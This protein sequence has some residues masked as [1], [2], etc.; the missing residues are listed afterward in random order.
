MSEFSVEA[1]RPRYGKWHLKDRR[2]NQHWSD[3]GGTIDRGRVALC[4]YV[5][6]WNRARLDRDVL[7]LLTPRD[8]PRVCKLCLRA[9]KGQ[10]GG[11]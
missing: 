2:I 10:T 3:G 9:L 1:F 5:Q 6:L 4:G 11:V 8:M 7:C